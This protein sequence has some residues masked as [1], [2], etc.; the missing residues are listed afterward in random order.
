MTLKDWIKKH[1]EDINNPK[2]TILYFIRYL[3]PELSSTNDKAKFVFL[4]CI[5]KNHQI[6]VDAQTSGWLFYTGYTYFY[7]IFEAGAVKDSPQLAAEAVGNI[8]FKG[9]YKE[10]LSK[11]FHFVK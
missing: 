4:W 6:N 1:E 3:L 7:E 5:K 2:N 9:L 11:I 10:E 8:L